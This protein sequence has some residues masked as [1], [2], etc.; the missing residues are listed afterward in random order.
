ML[1]LGRQGQP[2]AGRCSG[3]GV[4]V[5]VLDT[6]L[7]L[8]GKEPPRDG[9]C[10]TT[11]AAA[12]EVSPGGRDARRFEG[13]LAAGLQV[14]E[15]EQRALWTVQEAARGAGTEQRL[16]VADV[17]LLALALEAQ[18]V[19]VTDD[20]TMLDVARRLGVATQTV[21]TE[22]ISATLDFRPRCAGCGR[23]FDA[24][25]KRGDCPVCGS[26][27]AAKPTRRRGD[28]AAHGKGQGTGQPR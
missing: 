19:L 12:H 18:A 23:W 28:A 6:S 26:P 9:T 13:W 3:A 7:L 8:G 17:S 21:N 20:H 14:R 22:G 27:V 5:Y 11:P 1:V 24:M 25:P 16:S 10:W 15:P 4:P 2:L